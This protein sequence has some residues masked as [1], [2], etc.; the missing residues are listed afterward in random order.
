[1]RKL[2]T[3]VCLAT[4]T[5][6]GAQTIGPRRG[7]LILSGAGEPIAD[8]SVVRRFVTLAGGAESEIVYIPSA[9][10]SIRLPSGYIAELPDSGGISPDVATLE[11]ELAQFFGVRRVRV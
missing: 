10:S 2:A 4:A 11:R 8:S 5:Q 3:L 1:M 6:L 9:A 7:T